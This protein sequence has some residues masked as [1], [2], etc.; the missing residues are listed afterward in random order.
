ML[1]M[2][3]NNT[4]QIIDTSDAIPVS[5][6]QKVNG[7]EL[8]EE[9]D[10]T[11][12]KSP[13]PHK[14]MFQV[15]SLANN[16]DTFYGI[17]DEVLIPVRKPKVNSIHKQEKEHLFDP[18]LYKT[19]VSGWQ[20]ITLLLTVFLLGFTKAFSN[21]RFKQSIRALVNFSVAQEINREEKVFFH[22]ANIFLTIIHALTLSL[23]IYQLREV[24]QNTSKDIAPFMVFLFIAGSIIS[25]YTIKYLFSKM[26]FFIFND[27]GI[28]SEYI[29]NTSLFNNLLGVLLIPV[30]AIVYYTSFDFYFI[31]FYIAIPLIGLAFLLKLIRL[32]IIGNT[33]G[34]SYFYIFLYICTLEILPLVVLYRIF[35]LK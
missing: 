19:E 25:I 2:N 3:N 6:G 22:R 11:K 16:Q 33:K 26:L 5:N 24:F 31:L 13:K 30:L 12:V 10:T 28:A 1:Y 35:I 23:F 18:Q 21:N 20:T 4:Y 7:L 9:V 29:F 27:T 32:F 14:K 15:D 8:F 17:K 34:I